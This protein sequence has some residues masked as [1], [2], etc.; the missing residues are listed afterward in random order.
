M[1]REA[2]SQQLRFVSARA[3]CAGLALGVAL[4]VLGRP[5]SAQ[6]SA[7]VGEDLLTA[8]LSLLVAKWKYEQM[9]TGRVSIPELRRAYLKVLERMDD[10][11]RA[12]IRGVCAAH[13]MPVVK[14]RVDAAEPAP[15]FPD[16]HAY[17]LKAIEASAKRDRLSDLYINL[18][19]QAQ[20]YD[21]LHFAEQAKFLQN[22]EAGLTRAAIF[23]AANAGDPAY[24]SITGQQRQL[25]CPLAF[26]AGYAFGY[27]N[28][29]K[30]QP[31]ELTAAEA[32]RIVRA[33]YDPAVKEI[34]L[35]G[36]ATAVS[37]A[38]LFA[39][40]WLGRKLRL[41]NPAIKPQVQ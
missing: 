28:P 9:S 21:E 22:N 13:R 15:V 34:A 3:R 35:N 5:T 14:Q 25:H 32:E 17:C 27:R 20:G 12:T 26:D 38:G 33:C 16:V 8:G 24:A 2:G 6:E 7:A 1:R 11:E 39:G 10:G 18:A 41:D 29:E 31:Y 40:A 23:K 36:E 30:S 19:L 4:A 37:R